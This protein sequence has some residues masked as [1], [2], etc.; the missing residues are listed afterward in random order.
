MKS[1]ERTKMSQAIL[2]IVQVQLL[3]WSKGPHKCIGVLT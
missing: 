2:K 1:L 3:D